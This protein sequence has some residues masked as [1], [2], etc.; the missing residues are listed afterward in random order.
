M[1]SDFFI[2]QHDMVYTLTNNNAANQHMTLFD[3]MKFNINGNIKE[4]I[5]IP[6]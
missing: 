5:Y 3:F 2:M 1:K 6:S 4:M